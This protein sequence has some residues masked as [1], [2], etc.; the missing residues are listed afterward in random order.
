MHHAR[1]LGLVA[2]RWT[3]SVRA[4]G[5]ESR[6]YKS[7]P[8]VDKRTQGEQGSGASTGKSAATQA[9]SSAVSMHSH[10]APFHAGLPRPSHFSSQ[11][12]PSGP[13]PAPSQNPPATGNQPVPMD[14]GYAGCFNCRSRDH[15][16]RD[17]PHPRHPHGRGNQFSS[18]Y[19]D[20]KGLYTLNSTDEAARGS[21]ARPWRRM[22]FSFDVAK[23]TPTASRSQRAR[24][25]SN[26]TPAA[27]G[28]EPASLRDM[29]IIMP[30]AKALPT[31]AQDHE[32]R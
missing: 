20:M 29:Q 30:L 4:R 17:C 14:I 16:K 22:P 8:Q 24:I 19:A 28:D 23:Q 31:L 27:P 9:P 1:H 18:N 3:L 15:Y 6:L 11:S 10:T 13:R 25:P 5:Q 26:A 7:N 2:A 32:A 12:A 21:H